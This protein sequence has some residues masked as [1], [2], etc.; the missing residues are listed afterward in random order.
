M[1]RIYKHGATIMLWASTIGTTLA[2][3]QQ[4]AHV[5]ACGNEG[6]SIGAELQNLG[7]ALALLLYTFRTKDKQYIAARLVILVGWA[8]RAAVVYIT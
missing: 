8:A 4:A 5:L 7:V 2:H 6:V 3:F 1:T